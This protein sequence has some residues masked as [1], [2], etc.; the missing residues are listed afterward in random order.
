MPRRW[1]SIDLKFPV[2]MTAIVL[3]TSAVLMGAA[4]QR[5]ADTLLVSGGER[6]RSAARIV[7]ADIAQG[8]P[9]IRTQMRTLSARPELQRAL[10]ARQDSAEAVAILR[11]LADSNNI[12]ARVIHRDG[13]DLWRAAYDASPLAPSW[14]AGRAR[15]GALDTTSV[16]VSPL[17]AIDSQ[18]QYEIA[19]P[20]ALP[21]GAIGGFVVL[22]RPVRLRGAE[23][24]QGLVGSSTMLFGSPAEGVWSELGRVAVPPPPIVALDSVLRFEGSARGDGIGVAQDIAGTPWVVWMEFA[25]PQVLAPVKGLARQM[26]LAAL[27][28]TLLAI[29]V[30][31]VASRRITRRIA[32][33]NALVDRADPATV[34]VTAIPMLSD[35]RDEID[36]LEGSFQQ[37]LERT[38]EQQRIEA[39]LQQSQKLEAVGRLAGGIAHDFNNVLTVVSNYSELVVAGL[40]PGSPAAQD[41]KEIQLASERAARLTRQL[42]AFSGRQ[43]LQPVRLD[44]ND[45]L[46]IA[47]RLLVRVIPTH[48]EIRHEPEPRIPAVLADPGQIEQVILNLALNAA[49]AMPDGGQLTFRTALITAPQPSGAV[50][51]LDDMRGDHVALIVSDTGIGMSPETADR[52]F[53]PFFT[54]KPAGKGTGLGLPSVHGIVTQLGGRILVQSELGTGTTFTLFFPAVDGA[55]ESLSITGT[56]RITPTGSGTILLVED[57]AATRAV[58]R[59]ILVA[60]GFTVLEAGDGNEALEVIRAA[61]TPIR[62]VLSDVMMPG[63]S[64]ITLAERIATE[65]PSLPV[66]LMSGY[67]HEEVREHASATAKWTFVHKPFTLRSLREAVQ[68]VLDS[69]AHARP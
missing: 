33:L 19:H 46:S 14:A 3:V 18:P 6:L 49:D 42:L 36:R 35:G 39:H 54:T 57:D 21:G 13:S 28:V 59:R 65:W 52:I 31:W 11:S 67:S 53:E 37:L 23:T 34:R 47:L 48:I 66:L 60:E 62:M 22:T 58:T 56:H 68:D 15:D 2:L 69:A 41:M 4:Y 29:A 32:R 9:P 25:R 30:T 50:R 51:G 5:F 63:M 1:L 16:S 7:A 26:A 44:L 64:G 38:R 12:V 10:V 8:L 61:A 17:I 55:A 40:P 43:T 45:A 24:V 20:I 27:L